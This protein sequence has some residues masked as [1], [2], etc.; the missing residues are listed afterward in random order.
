MRNSMRKTSFIKRHGSSQV[1]FLTQIPCC[2]NGG[3]D[4]NYLM[5]EVTWASSGAW[6]MLSNKAASP[7]QTF[8]CGG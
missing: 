2:K 6:K 1:S 4:N 8:A 7:G 5:K 3:K